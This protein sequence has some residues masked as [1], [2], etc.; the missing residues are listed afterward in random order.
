MLFSEKVN[1]FNQFL[2]LDIQ[3]PAGVEVMN[4]FEGKTTF[5]LAKIFYNKYYSDSNPRTLLL[6][7]NPG[8]LGGGVTGIPFTDPVKLEIN[9]SIKNDLQ[10]KTEPSAGFI[11]YMINAYGGPDEFYNKYFIYAVCPL[12]FTKNGINYNYY[13]DKEL[14]KAVTP[15]I[16]D[17]LKKVLTFNVDKEFCYCLG[18]GKNYKFL[19]NLNN[20]HY[21]FKKVVPL[22][23]PRWIV[24]YRSKRYQEFI[25]NYLNE[26]LRK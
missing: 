17:S 12:G 11:Y 18:N 10:K 2:K 3:L 25:A 21:F 8:R 4:P 19:N 7:I 26:L 5:E 24:Q 23:H 1:D 14:E 20:I 16:I 6:G 22:P 9:C 13:D 15:F